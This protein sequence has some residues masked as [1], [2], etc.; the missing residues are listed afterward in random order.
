MPTSPTALFGL[1]L[2]AL[3]LAAAARDLTSFTIPNAI[4]VGL[5]VAFPMTALALGFAP[6]VMAVHALI[7]ALG[8]LIGMGLFALGKIGGG[9]AKLLAAAALWLGW[10]ATGAFLL[11]TA[12]AGGLLAAT[13]M[14]L[15][16]APARSRIEAGPDWLRRL[17]HP[18]EGVP[19]GVA[20]AAGVLVVFPSTPF[21]T[22][23]GL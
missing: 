1:V 9:D 12:L 22:G 15:R 11:S 18:G 7:G 4:P 21:A 16:S 6:G 5:A 2:P 23:L 8:L 14:I 13:L 17:A 20:I 10:P 3:M 19:Y